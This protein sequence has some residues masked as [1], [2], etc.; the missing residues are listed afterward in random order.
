MTDKN[1]STQKQQIAVQKQQNAK[2]EPESKDA[3]LNKLGNW[4]IKS[5]CLNI[6]IKSDID[7]TILTQYDIRCPVCHSD[8]LVAKEAVDSLITKVLQLD[9]GCDSLIMRYAF[10]PFCQIKGFPIIKLDNRCEK[11]LSTST[12]IAQLIY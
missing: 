5:G 6:T 10:N 9:D 8:L 2:P 11:C 1:Q 3:Y 7:R 12:V 4:W